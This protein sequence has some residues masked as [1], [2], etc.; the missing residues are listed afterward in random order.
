MTFDIDTDTLLQHC[1]SQYHCWILR[2]SAIQKKSADS[3][4]IYHGFC[5]YLSWILWLS[6][7]NIG[8]RDASASKK[9]YLPGL[10]QI[11][12]RIKELESSISG[13]EEEG[14]GGGGEA[15]LGAASVEGEGEGEK[16]ITNQSQVNMETI[17]GQ[18]VM[19]ESSRPFVF[20]I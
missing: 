13:E 7:T 17:Q 16:S 8:L 6:G 11:E 15:A 1:L 10:R 12:N 3:A 19:A 4:V 2:L 18:N 14:G 9:E 5:G 20:R